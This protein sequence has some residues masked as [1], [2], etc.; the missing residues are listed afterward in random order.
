MMCRLAV[1]SANSFK[2]SQDKFWATQDKNINGGLRFIKVEVENNKY[3]Q[4]EAKAVGQGNIKVILLVIT[5]NA[6]VK[7][8][9]KFLTC[10]H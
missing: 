8:L 10:Y 9:H 5:I 1:Y 4:W 6:I 2:K 3:N 7:I